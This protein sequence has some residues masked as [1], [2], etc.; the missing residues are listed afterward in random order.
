M[1]NREEA[2]ER[3]SRAVD[4]PMMVLA[5]AMIPLL[6]VPL[7]MTWPPAPSR[8]LPAVDDLLWA[9]FAVEY[10]VKLCLT[11]NRCRESRRD[12]YRG[13]LHLLGQAALVRAAVTATV[14]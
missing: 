10:V 7:V 13:R 12:P 9:A 4:G 11:S 8:G 3:F 14:A 5:L 6:V 2:F 1:S